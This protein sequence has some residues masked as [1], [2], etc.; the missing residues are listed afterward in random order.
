MIQYTASFT[1]LYQLSMAQVFFETGRKN[2]TA[3]FDYFFRKLPFDGVYKLTDYNGK[4]SIKLSEYI[5]KISIPGKKQ[6]YRIEDDKGRWIGAD[7][8][9][10]RDENHVENMYDPFDPMKSL[11]IKNCNKLP[12]LGRVMENG[13]RT[14]SKKSPAEIADFTHDQIRKLPEEHKRFENPHI[15]KVGLSEELHALRNRLIQENKKE[16]L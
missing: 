10:L 16:A 9:A 4:P 8:V 11:V 13:K 6:V 12:L 14:I 2:E 5:K 1:D 3:V 7:V 15:Y